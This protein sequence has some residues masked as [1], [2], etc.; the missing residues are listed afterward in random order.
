VLVNMNLRELYHLSRLREDATAQ[1]DIR[2]KAH[3]MSKAAKKVMPITTQLL[4]SKSEYPKLYF[5][6]FGRHPKTTQVP[7]PEGLC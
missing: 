7:P 5:R 4:G 1:W 2:D 6:L 3:K